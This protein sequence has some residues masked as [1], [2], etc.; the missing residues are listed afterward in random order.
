[1]KGLSAEPIWR[2][3]GQSI[4]WVAWGGGIQAPRGRGSRTWRGRGAPSGTGGAE[5]HLGRAVR[6]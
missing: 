5:G 3:M 1:M 4:A 2:K 6:L